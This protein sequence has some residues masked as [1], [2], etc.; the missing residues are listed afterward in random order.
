MMKST[1]APRGIKNQN[2]S[3][4]LL[5]ER[6]NFRETEKALC[7]PRAPIF[8]SLSPS[9]ALSLLLLTTLNTLDRTTLSPPTVVRINHS[10]LYLKFN[11]TT[12]TTKKKKFLLK[13]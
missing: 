6:R 12:T 10:S 9:L 13:E 5:C 4:L 7:F 8:F 11:T 2:S 3:L 1:S